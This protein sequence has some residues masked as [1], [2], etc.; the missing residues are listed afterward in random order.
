MVF[1]AI[2]DPH[3]TRTVN[4]Q[5]VRDPF[6]GNKIA[7]SQ[8]DPVAVNI[9]KVGLTSPTSD[10]MLRNIQKLSTGQPFFKEHI[11]GIKV[12]EVINDKNRV[13]VFFNY[14]YRN[15]NNNNG[16]WTYLPVPGAPTTTW[17]DQM[18]PSQMAR[19]TWTST[20]TPTL[21]SNF[22]AGYNRFLNQNGAPLDTTFQ[23]WAG[24]IGIQNT[25]DV[26]FPAFRFGGS[27]YQGG[28]IAGIG[29][30]WWGKGSNGS[31][32]FRDDLTKISGKHTFHFGYQY[33]RYFY[34]ESNYSDP[35]TFNFRPTETSLP[36]YATQTGNAFA[37]FMLGA[38]HNASHGIA[39]MSDG[40]RQPYHALWIM[41]DIKVTPKLTV[42]IGLRWE[43][44]TPFWEK[45]DRM[46]YISLGE[47]DP[48]AGNKRIARLPKPAVQHVLG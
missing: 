8:F 16:S 33:A 26:A 12:D 45:T 15:R 4:G 21:L 24:Q 1:G 47:T 38:V 34:D 2:Y 40:F 9:L 10:Q 5:T 37:S 39:G 31:W 42:N 41:D 19:V 14:G 46:S 23:N 36:G 11:F 48:T 17:Q 27:D 29:V 43:I 30:G 3:S 22:A 28:T 13:A 35:G 32:I 6:P 25:S 7:S 18:T 44:I 20:I